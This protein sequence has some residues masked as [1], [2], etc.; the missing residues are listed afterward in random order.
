[1]DIYKNKIVIYLKKDLICNILL[2]DPLNN[3]KRYIQIPEKYGEITP[4]LNK[5]TISLF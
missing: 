1:M 3:T 4:C 2:F 5:V